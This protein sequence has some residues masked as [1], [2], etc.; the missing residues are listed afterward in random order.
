MRPTH[1]HGLT[2]TSSHLGVRMSSY[3][4]DRRNG[5]GERQF[6]GPTIEHRPAVIAAQSHCRPTTGTGC[7]TASA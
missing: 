7:T 3:Q 1:D 5:T 2:P 4:I 6:T